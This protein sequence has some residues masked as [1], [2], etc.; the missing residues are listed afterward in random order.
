MKTWIGSFVWKY[1]VKNH[2]KNQLSNINIDNEKSAIESANQAVVT[3]AQSLENEF[4]SLEAVL[5]TYIDAIET[6][7]YRLASNKNDQDTKVVAAL[8][9]VLATPD[10]SSIEGST[11]ITNGTFKVNDLTEVTKAKNDITQA[12]NDLNGESVLE[13]EKTNLATAAE[14]EINALSHL[15]DGLKKEFTDQVA[16]LDKTKKA[17]TKKDF[18][19]LVDAI[20][21]Q[22]QT[23]NDEYPKVDQ[24]VKEY[25]ALISTNKYDLATNQTQQNS[26][27]F[28][29]LNTLLDP[30]V[31]QPTPLTKSFSVTDLKMKSGTDVA[32]INAAIN[33]IHAAKEELNGEVE[34]KKTELKTVL[35][36]ASFSNMDVNI[37]DNLKSE[38]DSKTSLEQLKPIETKINNANPILKEIND[39]VT[40]L[41]NMEVSANYKLASDGKQASFNAIKNNIKNL[42]LQNLFEATKLE[43]AKE[44]LIT[45]NDINL[46]G[47]TNLVAA[48]R[49]VNELDTL[50]DDQK[51]QAIQR[52]K[53]LTKVDTK[54]KLDDAAANATTINTALKTSKTTVEGLKHVSETAKDAAKK[55]LEQINISD[56]DPM[57]AQVS[58]EAIINPLTAL[59]NEFDNLKT[60]LEK[61]IATIG[62]TKHDLADNKNKLDQD[63][64]AALASVLNNPPTTLNKN[65]DIENLTFSASNA[66]DVTAAIEKINNAFKK[67][68]GDEVLQEKIIEFLEAVKLNAL[69][70]ATKE[71]ITTATNSATTLA[72]LDEVKTKLET[73]LENKAKLEKAISDLTT[74]KEKTNY[75]LADQAKKDAFDVQL[76][77]LQNKLANDNIYN[78]TTAEITVLLKPA[79]DAKNVLNGENIKINA[80]NEIDKLAN[81]NSTERINIKNQMDDLAKIDSKAKLDKL[82]TDYQDIN[83]DI[84]TKKTTISGLTHLAPSV[85]N[86]FNEK[87]ENIDIT[88]DKATIK[89]KNA[90]ILTQATDLNNKFTELSTKLK[91]YT[92]LIGSVKH[93]LATNKDTQDATVISAVNSI[94]ETP[95]LTTLTNTITINDGKLNVNDIAKV[96]EAINVIETAINSLDGETVLETQKTQLAN[97][98]KNAISNLSHLSPELAKEFTD[99][100][101]ALPKDDK[102]QD[103]AA[104]ALEV[105][106]IKTAAENLNSE[107]DKIDQALK[108]YL[109]VLDKVQYTEATNTDTQDKALFD[110]LNEILQTQVIKPDSFNNSY[111]IANP[112]M[113]IGTTSDKITK[114]VQA[115]AAAKSALNGESV[116]KQQKI[117]Y[118]EAIKK[119]IGALNHISVDLTSEFDEQIDKIA[120]SH[121]D[122]SD[123]DLEAF[124]VLV[125]AVKTT[126]QKLNDEYSKVNDAFVDYQ[127]TIGTNAYDHATNQ[128]DQNDAVFAALNTLVDP[129]IAKPTTLAKDYKV[130]SLKLAA[131]T[132]LTKLTKAVENIKAAKAALNGDQVVLKNKKDKLKDLLK[133]LPL[134]DL[135]EAVKDKLKKEIDSKSDLDDLDKIEDRINAA[136]NV[137][138]KVKAEIN[139]L[140][141][142]K[143]TPNYKLADETNKNNLD[144]ALA[145]LN[146]DL[147]KD[148]FDPNNINKANEN[149]NVA[150]NVTLNGDAN[151]ETAKKEIDDLLNLSDDQKNQAKAKLDEIAN[152][153]NN[154]IG[155]PT[156]KADLDVA[157]ENFKA[158][159]EEVKIAKNK[160]A[161]LNHLNN[162]VINKAKDDISKID[163][164]DLASDEVKT[165]SD[166][167]V[168]KLIEVNNQFDQLQT[169]LKEYTDTIGTIKHD[170]T[171]D[172]NTID[173]GIKSWLVNVLD[174]LPSSELVKNYNI[175]GAKLKTTNAEDIQKAITA[176]EDG[177]SKLN[178]DQV[179]AAKIKELIDKLTDDSA[180]SKLNQTTKAEIIA[181]A[182]KAQTFEK[183][184]E[185]ENKANQAVLDQNKLQHLINDLKAAKESVNYKLAN[186]TKQADFDS[187]LTA[188]ENTL[189]NYDLYDKTSDEI[190]SLSAS[191]KNADTALDGNSN[192]EKALKDIEGMTNIPATPQRAAIKSQANNLAEINNKAALDN[193][194]TKFSAANATIANA[195]TEIGK[196]NHLSSELQDQFK[197]KAANIDVDDDQ[198]IITATAQK[199]VDD[200]KELEAKFTE[201]A[202]EA[203]KYKDAMENPKYL[204]ADTAN[205]TL[206]NQKVQEA[207]ES[208]LKDKT[209]TDF[210]S[211]FDTINNETLKSDTTLTNVENAIAKI[212]DALNSLD[213]TKQVDDVKEVLKDKVN[214]L[215]GI[216]NK[217]NE[218]TKDAILDEI[219]NN[220][221]DTKAEVNDI[222][223]KAKEALDTHNELTN[224]VKE[225][226]DF[227]NN[228]NYKLSSD[229]KKTAFDD[230]IAK[231][232]EEL[233]Q[234]LLDPNN[235]IKSNTALSAADAAKTALDGNTN[236]AKAKEEIDKLT[237]L[238]D[239]VQKDIKNNLDTIAASG[240]GKNSK[241]T[242]E[243]DKAKE[244]AQK[245]A[246]TI[247]AI[248]GQPNLSDAAKTALKDQAKAIDSNNPTSEIAKKLDEVT[249]KAKNLNYKFNNLKDA[250]NKYKDA[251]DSTKYNDA[252]SENKTEQ[253][254]AVR[255]A[256]NNVLDS[257]TTPNTTTELQGKVKAGTTTIDLDQAIKDIEKALNNLNGDAE[258]QKAKNNLIDKTNPGNTLDPLNE[259]TKNAIKEEVNNATSKKDIKDISDK[260][261]EALNTLKTIEEEIKKLNNSKVSDD[262]K[263]ASDDKKRQLD[264]ALKEL[265]DLKDSNLIDTSIKDKL[266]EGKTNSDKSIKALDG[267]KNL[268]AAKKAIDELTNLLPKDHEKAKDGI[269]TTSLNDLNKYVDDIEIINNEIKK[270]NDF[271]DKLPNLSD[272][273][274]LQ[275]KEKIAEAVDLD[276]SKNEN[277]E[278]IKKVVDNILDINNYFKDFEK[279]IDN[280]L[281][282]RQTPTYT[283]ATN[284]AEQDQKFVNALNEVLVKPITNPDENIVNRFKAEVNEDKINEVITKI[285]QATT[286][287]NGNIEVNKFKDKL[288]D[289]IDNDAK[290]KHLSQATKE[291]LKSKIRAVNPNE[292]NW[293]SEL[294]DILAETKNIITRVNQVLAK[295]IKLETLSATK[296]KTEISELK[297]TL[298]QDWT[299]PIQLPKDGITDN[300]NSESQSTNKLWW[301]LSLLGLIPLSLAA[302]WAKLKKKK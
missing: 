197:A 281:S 23:V 14:N 268:D 265:T 178:G 39:K 111:T 27:L 29:A 71:A 116:L 188:L 283:A 296:Y 261:D 104:F 239:K 152:S 260:A 93:D 134:N 146:E 25:L 167:I 37:I 102:T 211:E 6:P 217:L 141:V 247:Q 120:E 63:V 253:D 117:D 234:N 60:E 232:K 109:A 290:Y 280:Y 291:S 49:S 251:M 158:I 142:K 293:R 87:L 214:N 35:A 107:Y 70:T 137:M 43:Q 79:Q 245:L 56:L 172:V 157:I 175:G 132:D 31:T 213:G 282:V 243:V 92:D 236:L 246:D 166:E 51:T 159:D 194:I 75:K 48:E 24:A 205:Q 62:K 299:R 84:G 7:K 5:K 288:I 163:I 218:T 248:D 11:T 186:P 182:N 294:N 263:L 250:Y 171:N 45:F 202:K 258:L 114:A 161:D 9:L 208:V 242:D 267:Q 58:I 264:K 47:D 1:T 122:N 99:K 191:A 64:L 52:I 20:K 240:N 130:D 72:E 235:K 151:L 273:A 148:L 206:Q 274:K 176:I 40:E 295:I 12:F 244:I 2:F 44:T 180:L 200:A 284:S 81:I 196:L 231:L 230:A 198:T 32:K 68:N 90:A 15:S 271:I 215:N 89:S 287:L 105:A 95:Q 133:N 209:Y 143:A 26:A 10:I 149:I 224:K 96:A 108:D 193:L 155:N 53:N 255:T 210:S 190:D 103:K 212:Q 112:K 76:T 241:L 94:L 173:Q 42:L 65:I 13:A 119:T 138:E 227:K 123:Q 139:D 237:N 256:T 86:H 183:L 184:K 266:V 83:S 179:L 73:T 286:D 126:A 150:K 207:L 301:L 201:L 153:V 285:K 131:G 203:E 41:R 187:K 125:N 85:Q 259:A 272:E 33:A 220:N 98:A 279:V 97:D 106:K 80:K 229:V 177:L 28:T 219:N 34:A 115:I 36:T 252:T 59:N 46:D 66:D 19:K 204:E 16:V 233:S 160:I 101:D 302:L 38:I 8:K 262:Y 222:D 300:Q 77:E 17:E 54:K 185:I 100:I 3:T 30:E 144:E 199:H 257:P 78:K 129:K 269:P 162:V 88:Q 135:L 61:Y 121:S 226:E 22:A 168:N 165:K 18:K 67:L 254:E 156:S 298:E 164:K 289:M 297:K 270:Q 292:S 74:E 276:K 145:K 221:T 118:A 91:N 128:D 189:A 57:I 127:N 278:N 124:K 195:N 140:K 174:N 277:I 4:S 223:Q 154:T 170:L 82:V 216:Y 238:P 50:S 169:K 113:K 181:E 21:A 110:A 275:A 249:Q 225:L 192:L 69:N 228:P 55:Q 147:T 136:K